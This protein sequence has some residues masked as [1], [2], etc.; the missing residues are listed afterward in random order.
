MGDKTEAPTSKRRNDER[1]KGN[2]F[3]SKEILLLVSLLA[4][5][6][7]IQ[8]MGPYML[9]A[10]SNFTEKTWDLASTVQVMSPKL[11]SSLFIDSAIAYG[12]SAL[13]PLLAA[14][15]AAILVTVAQ[16]RGLFSAEALKPK[17][18]RM[19]PAQ[20]I[21]KMFSARGLVELLKSILKIIVLI[22]VVYGELVDR[23]AELPRLMEMDFV[24]VLFYTANAF[25]SMF[26]SV[27]FM[28]VVLSAADYMY[29][30]WQY[31]KDLRMS[32]QEIKEEYKQTEGDPQVKGKIK[33][34]QREMSQ[35]RMMAEVPKADVIVRNPTHYA[36]A[37]KYDAKQHKSPQVIAKGADLLALRII[38]LAEES[39][40]VVVEN[41]PLARALYE[42]VP[43][44]REVPREFFDAVAEVLV[45]VYTL[46]KR[47][48]GKGKTPPS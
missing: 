44:E 16:T 47:G 28:F 45:Y 13:P 48:P 14:A 5:V 34:K 17:F 31:E 29:Q 35:S 24:N 36:V 4:V 27:L 37:L 2:V 23:L 41:R 3:Q 32:K 9:A 26:T 1:K 22:Y 46:Q 18:S 8:F 11:L 39:N 19:N 38:K 21:K 12:I 7:T 6:Y 43:L 25:L 10:L 42:Q 33:Q 30:R 15:L 40:V 20:G